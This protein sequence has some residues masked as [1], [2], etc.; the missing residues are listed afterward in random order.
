MDSQGFVAVIKI[1]KSQPAEVNSAPFF[2]GFKISIVQK[3]FA[4]RAINDE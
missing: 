2:K 4:V 1:T 3:D